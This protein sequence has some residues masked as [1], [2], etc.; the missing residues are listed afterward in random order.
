MSFVHLHVHTQYSILDGGSRIKSLYSKSKKKL[1]VGLIDKAKEYEMPGIAITDHGNMFGVMEFYYEAKAQGIVP[2]IGCEVYVAPKSRFDKRVEG[3]EEKSAHHLVLL[4]KD[5]EG[6]HNLIKLVS[7]GYT[8]GF[9]YRP[10]VDNELIEK[11]HKGLV[12]LSACMGGSIPQALRKKDSTG[13]NKLTQ[14]YKSIFEDDFYIELQYHGIP[15]ETML[16]KDLFKVAKNNDV[17]MVITNDVHYVSKEDA[18][19]HEILLAIQTK[20]ILTDERRFKFPTDDFHLKSEEEIMKP[21]LKL[22]SARLNT[23]EIMEKCKGL[24]IESKQIFMP[25]YP[26]SKDETPATALRN[27]CIEGLN[28]HYNNNIPDAAMDRLNM[29]LEVISKMGFEGYFLIVQDFINYARN[30]DISVGP[31]RGSAAGSIVAFGT[32]IT[33]VNP[34]DYNLLFERFLN[35][36]RKSMPDI[37]V[38]FQ[39]DKRELVIDYVKEKYGKANVAQIATFSELGG[40]SVV[41]DVCRVMGIEL[42]IA[43]KLSKLMP[44]SGTVVDVYED[45]Q[46]IEFKNMIDSS[47]QLK[48]MYNIAIK[49]EGLV[50]NVGIHAAGVVISSKEISD[51]VPVYQDAKT[52]IRACQYEMNNIEKAGLIKMD[53]LGIK[54]L[55]LIKDAIADIKKTNNIEVDIDKIPFDDEKVF[56]IFRTANTGGVFQF[57]SDGM[58]KMLQNISP[59]EFEDLVSSV[60]LYRPGPLGSGMDKDYADYKN[61]RKP[62]T[63]KHKD[64]EPILRETQGVLI[65]QEQIMAVSRVIGG[66]TAAE[67]DDLRKAMGKKIASAM[68]KNKEKFIN[69]GLNK[70]YDKSFL[71]ELF[72]MMAKFAE[73]GFNKS[74]S[75]CYALIAYQQGY[76]K[77]HYPLI[78]F[79]ALLNTTINDS[80][81]I[82]IYLRE[83]RQQKIEIVFPSVNSSNA[84][85]S[86]KDGKIIY[87]LHAIK[88]IGR[89]A[90]EH[91]ETERKENGEFANI[92]NFAERIN[93]HLVNRRVY[94]ALIKVGAFEEFGHNINSLLSSVDQILNHA[95]SYQK[96]VSSG[97]SMLFDGVTESSGSSTLNIAKKPELDVL[98]LKDMET[99]TMGF[100]LRHHPFSKY[101]GVIDY[102]YFNNILDFETMPKNYKFLLPCVVSAVRESKSKKT[103]A[104]MLIVEV[105]DLYSTKTFFLNDEKRIEKHGEFATLGMAI[106]I[107]GY[108]SKSKDGV[109]YDNINN[110]RELNQVLSNKRIKFNEVVRGS[111]NTDSNNSSNNSNTKPQNNYYNKNNN[112]NASNK[113]Q[114]EKKSKFLGDISGKAVL[115]HINKNRFDNIELNCLQTAISK[116][117]GSCPVYLNIEDE[118]ATTK[119]AIGDKY[120]VNPNDIF[121]E[122][123]DNI[124]SLVKISLI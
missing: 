49:L 31:G 6:Y 51:V 44:T 7:L 65:Y 113:E 68:A 94:E 91:I 47:G 32:G 52:G 11:Y 66:F 111:S 38:D 121:L 101:I 10:R 12:C 43:D 117:P 46:Y 25:E 92:E 60:A 3:S 89:E 85:F 50:R 90:A 36:E 13:A 122:E 22:Q 62:I 61:K 59:T 88:G 34:L 17:P 4:A 45:P 20:S 27:M 2:I 26:I 67:A 72:D 18:K 98:A 64:L 33:Q 112:S 82:E 5:L 24:D 73:Y 53:F 8:E 63:Y 95:N 100:T 76:I 87:G 15:E 70:G 109:Y 39:D 96:E 78:Y 110:I 93:T 84:M 77:A 16:N 21:F 105:L 9:Y 74:H 102:K 104:P 115:L 80:D 55:R 120:R 83:I 23:L 119:L 118:K 19:A 116:Y 69:G 37:D 30:N 124:R 97:Q 123:L 14:Y 41:K 86:H 81:K 57:E 48:S 40:K 107:D 103:N 42:S 1:S 106:L 79:V 28:K 54:N 71:E 114:T 56:E 108:R 29:E 99:E 35:P 58:R 75:V